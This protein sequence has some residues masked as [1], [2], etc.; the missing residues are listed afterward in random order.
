MIDNETFRK[1]IRDDGTVEGYAVETHYLPCKGIGDDPAGFLRVLIDDNATDVETRVPHSALI[2]AGWTPPAGVPAR[3]PW[4]RYPR[5]RPLLYATANASRA[6]VCGHCGAH[7][8]YADTDAAA[9]AAWNSAGGVALPAPRRWIERWHGSGPDRGWWV[10]EADHGDSIAYCGEGEFAERLCSLIVQKHNAPA[11]YSV[12]V[13][14]TLPA[15]L[16]P[17]MQTVLFHGLGISGRECQARYQAM[18]AA[19]PRGVTGT[20]GGQQ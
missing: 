7:G 9:D 12:G 16:T 20:G 2:A 15:V 8:P 14:Q 18:I 13:T 10:W 5:T 1:G 6:A 4:C 17:K 3:C 11:A 19:V